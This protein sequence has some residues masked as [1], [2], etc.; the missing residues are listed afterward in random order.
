MICYVYFYGILF[1]DKRLDEMWLFWFIL[2]WM[3]GV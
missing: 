1:V 2:L 3:G